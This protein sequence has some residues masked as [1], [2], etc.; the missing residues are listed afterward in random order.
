MIWGTVLT[1]AVSVI[2]YYAGRLI[3]I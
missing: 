3:G 2:G 1:G